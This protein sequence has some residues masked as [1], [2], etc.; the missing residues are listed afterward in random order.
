MKIEEIEKLIEYDNAY[1][2]GDVPLVSDVS[3]DRLKAKAQELYPTHLY[4]KTVGAAPTSNKVKLPYTLGSLKKKKYDGSTIKWLL[5]TVPNGYR[6]CISDKLDGCS[7]YVEYENGEVVFASTRGNGYEGQDITEKAKIFCDPIEDKSVCHFRGEACMTPETAFELGYKNA[8]NAVAGV[9]NRDG[10]RHAEHIKPIFYQ[11]LNKNITTYHNMFT[12]IL[13]LKLEAPSY[14]VYETITEE[15]LATI[16]EM[17]KHKS[18]Y[19]I[20]GLVIA[21]N[22]YD[23]EDEYY[24]SN[25]VAFKVNEDAVKTKVNKVEWSVTRTGKIMPVVHIKSVDISG[26]TVS[27]ATGFNAKF[28]KDNNIRKGT[29]I[30]IIKSGDVIPYLVMLD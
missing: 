13:D 6:V 24:P 27:K 5:E 19:D 8:R 28:I 9:L 2:N 17:R 11:V 26:S 4:F 1:Y 15:Q 22:D 16:L 30:G 20:D 29:E 21:H 7:I 12:F 25:M 23:H 14:F 10:L 18:S 3:Y